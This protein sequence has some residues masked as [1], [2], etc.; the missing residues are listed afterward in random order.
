LPTV[1]LPTAKTA[2]P[3]SVTGQV[4]EKEASDLNS[5]R[6]YEDFMSI[7]EEFFGVK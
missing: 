1:K 3:P 4:P 2:S 5:C 6:K 7:E